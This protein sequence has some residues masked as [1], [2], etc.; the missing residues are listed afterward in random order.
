[1]KHFEGI[2]FHFFLPAFYWMARQAFEP[3]Y[4]LEKLNQS[5]LNLLFVLP[6]K[7]R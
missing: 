6:L 4:R 7:T 1:M 2:F 3:Y 5:R